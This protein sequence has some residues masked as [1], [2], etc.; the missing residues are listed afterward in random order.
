MRKISGLSI[1]AA[2]VGLFAVSSASAQQAPQGPAT[3]P[4]ELFIC[5]FK[6]GNNFT[7][8][9]RAGDAF[10]KWADAHGIKALTSYLLTPV[11]H[12]DELKADV[13]GMDIWGSGEAMGDG[14]AM[15]ASDP[16]S[17]AAFDKVVDCGAHQLFV[18]IGIKPPADGLIKNGSTFQF[19]DCKLMENRNGGEAIQ[20]ATAW[21]N[22]TKGAGMTDAQALLFPAAGE[23]S[24]ADYT[25]KWITAGP[26]MQAFGKS[27]DQFL[28]GGLLQTRQNLMRNLMSCDSQRVYAT[29]VMR[30]SAND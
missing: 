8:L 21:G 20:A 30:E 19:T 4:V 22:A 2:C 27:I 29:T 7:N 17:T 26:S 9:Q 15:I 11:Y 24:D 5:N 3:L 14:T 28:S 25:F 6:A 16:A 23:S 10:N 18:L 1:C 12:S 13:I